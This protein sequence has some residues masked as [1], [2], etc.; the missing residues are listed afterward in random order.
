VDVLTQLAS[1]RRELFFAADTNG[2]GLI[3]MAELK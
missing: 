3:S 1:C 2:D